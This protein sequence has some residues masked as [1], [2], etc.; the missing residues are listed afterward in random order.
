MS[1]VHPILRFAA[2]TTT[3]HTSISLASRYE[4]L[5]RP[6]DSMELILFG[7]DML[8]CDNVPTIFYGLDQSGSMEPLKPIIL[9]NPIHQKWDIQK[10]V[11]TAIVLR[12]DGHVGAIVRNLLGGELFSE[13]AW[14]KVEDYFYRFL[15]L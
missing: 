2:V 10:D 8:F 14:N 9:T 4:D 15:V 1:S 13:L 7:P 5:F 11:G 3:E 12:P 6:R